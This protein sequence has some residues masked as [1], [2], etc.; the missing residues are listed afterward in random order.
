V[1]IREDLGAAPDVNHMRLLEGKRLASSLGGMDGS[2]CRLNLVTLEVSLID[3]SYLV[4]GPR[5]W[6][7][8]EDYSDY[9]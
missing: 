1:R 6:K 9:F 3:L 7:M 5:V 2:R 8:I 4:Y